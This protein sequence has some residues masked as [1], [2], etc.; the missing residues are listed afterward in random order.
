[1]FGDRSPSTKD[2]SNHMAVNSD[3][4]SRLAFIRYLHHLGLEQARLPEPQ[5]SAGVLMFHDAVEAFLLL[6]A[7]HLEATPS[8]NFAQYW[9]SLGPAKISNGVQL[10]SRQA[11]LRL[12]KVRVN[13]KHHGAMPGTSL[14]N[15]LAEDTTAFF[16]ANTQLV[17]G[18]DYDE[19]SMADLVVQ[20]KVRESVRRAEN[21]AAS[22]NFIEAMVTLSDAVELLLTPGED[23]L[24]RTPLRFGDTIQ[25]PMSVGKI[26]QALDPPRGRSGS[27]SD[28]HSSERRNLANQIE[29]VTAV[30]SKL[31]AIARL[32]ALGIEYTAYLRFEALTPQADEYFDGRRTHSAPEGYAPT[33]DEYAFCLQF[34]ISTSLRLAA[35]HTNLQPPSWRAHIEPN[36][37]L[38]WKTIATAETLGFG[39]L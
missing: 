28:P 36:A 21:A 31:Q 4:A 33:Y 29:R 14:V 37:V 3:V 13:L 35:A 7:E 24:G 34:A 17:F 16:A 27:V 1:M 20:D 22:G 32:S 2:D 10:V 39:Y 19:V 11:M 12:N 5:C 6:A 38:S 26:N 23:S 18:I 15:Q 25:R 9:D 30:V 8:A